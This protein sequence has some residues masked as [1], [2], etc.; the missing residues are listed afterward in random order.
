MFSYSSHG[1]E[2]EHCK[3]FDHWRK[4][5]HVGKLQGTEP[6]ENKE[7]EKQQATWSTNKIN[8]EVKSL[9]LEK[10]QARKVDG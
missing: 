3:P 5:K 2:I 7:L 8:R 9:E 4:H 10:Q 6:A 1:L